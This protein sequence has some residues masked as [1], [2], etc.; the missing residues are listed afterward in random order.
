MTASWIK[1]SKNLDKPVIG[2]FFSYK[3]TALEHVN[4]RSELH[5][6]PCIS[7]SQHVLE[8]GAMN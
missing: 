3:C 7:G 4:Q 2:T 8:V 5:C 6:P 1:F